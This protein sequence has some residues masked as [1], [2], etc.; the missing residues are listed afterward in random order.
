MKSSALSFSSAACCTATFT[1]C[2]V[3]LYHFVRFLSASSC[4]QLMVGSHRTR[5]AI[6]RRAPLHRRHRAP[7]LNM[8]ADSLQSTHNHGGGSCMHCPKHFA[9]RVAQHSPSLLDHFVDLSCIDVFRTDSY[10][11]C[12]GGGIWRSCWA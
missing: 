3:W 8:W 10:S 9:V 12:G 1:H 7:N 4:R 6:G 2:A 5:I 11:V